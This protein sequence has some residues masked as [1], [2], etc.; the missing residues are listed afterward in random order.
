MNKQTKFRHVE[1]G[2]VWEV[3]R[4]MVDYGAFFGTNDLHEEAEAEEIRFKEGIEFLPK[5]HRFLKPYMSRLD[6]AV[7]LE[8]LINDIKESYADMT[9]TEEYLRAS[10]DNLV[11]FLDAEKAKKEK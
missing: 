6:Q 5:L 8:F 11:E 7:L 2:V 3:T 4:T 10:A 1:G 9:Y